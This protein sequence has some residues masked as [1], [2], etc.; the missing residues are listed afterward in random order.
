[1]IFERSRYE[2]EKV[3]TVTDSDGE[4]HKAVRFPNYYPTEFVAKKHTIMQG[5]RLDQLASKYYD[6]PEMWWIIAVSNPRTAFYPDQIPPGTTI[7]I[8]HA[9]SV[10]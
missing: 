1:M 5:E 7:R 9:T 3:T 2:D 6:D 10:R 4:P 8:P